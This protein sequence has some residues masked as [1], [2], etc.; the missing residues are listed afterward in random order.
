MRRLLLTLLLAALPAGLSAQEKK[1]NK[2]EP[3][4][5]IKLDR[6]DPVAYEKDI[7]PI[8]ANKCFVCHSGKEINGKLDSGVKPLQ[9][10]AELSGYKGSVP[11]P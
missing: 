8:F 1:D 6:K 10:L 7:E 4:A 2:L 5:E 3:I 9:K 11:S